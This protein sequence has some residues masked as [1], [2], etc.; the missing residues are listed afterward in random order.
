MLATQRPQGAVSSDI[1]ANVTTM[2]ALRTQNSG[3]SRDL[4]DSPVA[5][6]IPVTARGRAYLRIG[7]GDAVLFQSA[8]STLPLPAPVHVFRTVDEWLRA[9]DG[10]PRTRGK[11]LNSSSSWWRK[12]PASPAASGLPG[13]RRL[14]PALPADLAVRLDLAADPPPPHAGRSITIG[15]LDLPSLQRQEPLRWWPE[16]PTG[17]WR[18]SAL[19]VAGTGSSSGR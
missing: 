10:R 13:A 18:F 16:A 15:L 3:E 8:S 7:T 14:L 2:V 9:D 1:R 19:T 12:L 6:D 4:L 5:A 17:I 11:A